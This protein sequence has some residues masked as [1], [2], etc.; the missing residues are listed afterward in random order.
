MITNKGEFCNRS[1]VNTLH[2]H[3]MI[4][5]PFANKRMLEKI[6]FGYASGAGGDLW[7]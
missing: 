1:G 5:T 4:I 2:K 7:N 3:N 6:K